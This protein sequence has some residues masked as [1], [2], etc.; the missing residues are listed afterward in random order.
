MHSRTEWPARISAC[1]KAQARKQSRR[2]KSRV[3]MAREGYRLWFC[4]CNDFNLHGVFSRDRP[5]LLF[6]PGAGV[7]PAFYSTFTEDL[8]SHGYAVF[9]IVPTGWVD[10]IFPDG[11]RV[12][13]SDKCSDYD[14]WITGTALP[15][16]AGDLRFMLDQIQRVDRDPSSGFFQ[17][18]DLNK[19]G[20][21]GH[22]FWGAASILSGLQDQRIRAVLNLDG[23]PFGVLLKTASKA[24]VGDEGRCLPE[25]LDSATRR[26]GESDRGASARRAFFRL[27][28]RLAGIPGGDH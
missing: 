16:W 24:V 21:F 3:S 25:V 11:H 17:R 20:V 5:L 8:A 9:A 4:K 13:A 27:F 10:T 18:L 12:P 26:K 7:N 23:S 19:I 6:S 1:R 22:S 28:E 2:E 14:K 15:L